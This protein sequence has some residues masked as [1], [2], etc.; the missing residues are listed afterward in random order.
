MVTRPA[1]LAGLAL[2]ALVFLLPAR[3]EDTRDVDALRK[4]HDAWIVAYV[5]GELDALARFYTPT[6]V[7]MPDQRATHR[8][9]GEIR[10]FFAAGIERFE[11]EAQ[12]QLQ[13]VVVSGD[14]ASLFGVVDIALTPKAGGET[15]RRT[16]RYLIVF[17]RGDDGEWRV[18]HDMD[19][20]A[21]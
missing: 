1:L 20:R 14:L 16:L 7:I 21:S 2:S 9:W 3:A 10:A 17:E 19:N 15:I 18:L 5:G 13:D 4:V 8:G 6:S 11:Y 12:A